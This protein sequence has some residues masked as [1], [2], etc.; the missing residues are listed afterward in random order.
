ML[1]L[2][3]VATALNVLPAWIRRR[4]PA[5]VAWEITEDDKM[6]A[7]RGPAARSEPW[8]LPGSHQAAFATQK[9]CSAGFS[10]HLGFVACSI[11]HL[12]DARDG[13]RAP[14]P[15]AALAR[16]PRGW[17]RAAP[18]PTPRGD[19]ASERAHPSRPP[20]RRPMPFECGCR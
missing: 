20:N 2:V 1:L 9:R 18:R 13:G 14:P 16:S 7:S 5:C 19:A 12:I 15:P 17:L 10:D 8:P 3:A 6:S 11:N 4:M